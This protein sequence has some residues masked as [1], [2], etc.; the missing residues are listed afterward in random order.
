VAYPGSARSKPNDAFGQPSLLALGDPVPRRIDAALVGDPRTAAGAVKAVQGVAENSL[1]FTRYE[2][3]AAGPGKWQAAILKSEENRPN[4]RI[5][6][7]D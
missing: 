2:S 4:L 5:V 1:D 6:G 7:N 3:A